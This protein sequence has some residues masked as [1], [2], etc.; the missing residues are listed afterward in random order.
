MAKRDKV[1]SFET[2]KMDETFTRESSIPH[3]TYYRSVERN[4][5]SQTSVEIAKN[6]L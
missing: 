1:K 2:E 3:N 5:W 6:L 4:D